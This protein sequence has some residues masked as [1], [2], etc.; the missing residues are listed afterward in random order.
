MNFLT[1][2]RFIEYFNLRYISQICIILNALIGRKDAEDLSLTTDRFV[3]IRRE[4]GVILEGIRMER[5]INDLRE[6]VNSTAK[7]IAYL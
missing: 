3:S 7:E 4:R 5:G 2:H 1:E 6:W